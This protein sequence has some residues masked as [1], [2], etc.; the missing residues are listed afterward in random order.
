MHTLTTQQIRSRS[1]RRP[2]RS[3]EEMEATDG[4]KAQHAIAQAL[5]ALVQAPFRLVETKS[6][7]HD[8]LRGHDLF[9]VKDGEGR[10]RFSVDVSLRCKGT[11]NCLQ[12]DR[13]MFDIPTVGP[14]RFRNTPENRITLMRRLADV[15]KAQMVAGYASQP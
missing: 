5:S 3:A 8:D 6:G 4:I 10:V 12:V 11:W 15:L 14:W 1:T 13:W 7:D 9:I 2:F